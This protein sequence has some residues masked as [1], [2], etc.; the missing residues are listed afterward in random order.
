MRRHPPARVPLTPALSRRRGASLLSDRDGQRGEPKPDE[1][2]GFVG[3][4]SYARDRVAGLRLPRFLGL[5][6]VHIPLPLNLGASA[7]LPIPSRCGTSCL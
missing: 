6:C 7:R 5:E 1:P 4:T 3:L 2:P